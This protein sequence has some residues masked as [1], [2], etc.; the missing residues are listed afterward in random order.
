MP[1]S[2]YKVVAAGFG[3]CFVTMAIRYRHL[4]SHFATGQFTLTTKTSRKLKDVARSSVL[5]WEK[6][7]FLTTL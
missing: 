7:V 2:N 3:H 5:A 1:W 6:I 4:I